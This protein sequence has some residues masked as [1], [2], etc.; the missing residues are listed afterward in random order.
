MPQETD[1]QKAIKKLER[2]Q[3]KRTFQTLWRQLNGPELQ[4]EFEFHPER[5][6]RFDFCRGMVAI[7]LE[8]GTWL[9]KSGHTTGKGYSKDC[10]KYNQAALLGFRVFRFTTDMLANDP[11]GHLLPVIEL[12]RS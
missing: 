11:V 2:E 9:E 5:H 1:I 12:M 8:G 4:E 6:W 3:L 7:E 10:Q